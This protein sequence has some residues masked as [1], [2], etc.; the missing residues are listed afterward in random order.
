LTHENDSLKVNEVDLKKSV[1]D[2]RGR[3]VQDVKVIKDLKNTVE[4]K[5]KF[6]GFIPLPSRK[7]VAA[8][9]AVVTTIFLSIIGR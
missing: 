6:L 3:V 5:D 1:E 8:T 9:T 4:K 2:L 7:A